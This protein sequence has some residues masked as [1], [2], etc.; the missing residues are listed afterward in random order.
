M[1]ST[2]QSINRSQSNLRQANDSQKYFNFRRGITKMMKR[3]LTISSEK[4][5]EMDFN[6]L[7]P[8]SY[9]FRS[10][11]KELLRDPNDSMMIK[12]LVTNKIEEWKGID[13]LLN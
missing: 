10:K 11:A 8:T 6:R 12:E 7:N 9:E 2:M 3:Q 13:L 4:N 5:E 1:I